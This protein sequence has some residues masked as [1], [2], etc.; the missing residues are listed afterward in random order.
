MATPEI[1]ATLATLAAPATPATPVQLV[2]P[3]K[4][5]LMVFSARLETQVLLAPL[6]QLV[7]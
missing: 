7:T 1:P 5:V 3:D 2:L 6:A 4:K